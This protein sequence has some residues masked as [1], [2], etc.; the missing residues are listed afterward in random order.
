MADVVITEFMSD[1]AVGLLVAN[2]SVLYERDLVDRP[3]DLRA[4]LADCR[5]LV[6]RNRTRVNQDLLNLAPKLKVVGRLGV[7]LD[8]IDLGACGTRGIA[9]YPATGA[10]DDSVA[11]YV[12]CSALMLMRGAFWDSAAVAAGLWPRE[13]LIGRELAGKN[14]GLVGFGG[15]ARATAARLGALGM[16]ISA[17]DPNI[18]EASPIWACV[19]RA[20]LD[21]ILT[22]SEVI[23][24]HV[25]LT[26][27][28]R[29]MI[30]AS[31]LAKMKPT[32]IL[33]NAARG[34]IV[35][36]AA[37]VESLKAARLGGAALDVFEQEP[38][39]AGQGARF[40]DVPNLLLTPH[41]AGVTRESNQRVSAKIAELVLAALRREGQ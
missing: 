13:K 9:V 11:E 5:A 14:A 19:H 29:H 2:T 7:G 17:T 4:S 10:N 8:N 30:D 20:S 24:L 40:A 23:S 36:E 27:Q 41:I 3:S 33:I 28:T 26:P 6:V 32:A 39:D 18:S 31:A 15:T 12:A 16:K 35:D 21:E 25:P 1:D 38:L 34:G 22:N 37:L